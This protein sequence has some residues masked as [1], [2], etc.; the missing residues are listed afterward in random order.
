MNMVLTFEE[1]DLDQVSSR[2]HR[3]TDVLFDDKVFLVSKT[4]ES[5]CSASQL[6]AI[7]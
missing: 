4:A 5:N 1:Y 3:I 6:D 7:M 2:T